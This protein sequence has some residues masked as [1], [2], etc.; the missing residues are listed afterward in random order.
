[1]PPEYCDKSNLRQRTLHLHDL[2]FGVL[3]RSVVRYH[4]LSLYGFRWSSSKCSGFTAL[5]PAKM[6]YTP[7]PTVVPLLERTDES[8]K[9][10]VALVPVFAMVCR[11]FSWTANPLWTM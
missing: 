5:M 3:L 7:A 9:Y 1:M 8:K 4:G 6:Q 2:P 11:S 10:P